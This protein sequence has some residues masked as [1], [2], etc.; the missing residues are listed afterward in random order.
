MSE[1]VCCRGWRGGGESVCVCEGECV[2]VC[3][4]EGGEVVERVSE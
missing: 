2:Q 3:V 1:S 4:V